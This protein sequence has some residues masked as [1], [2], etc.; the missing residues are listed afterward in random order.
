MK[1]KTNQPMLE[2]KSLNLYPLLPEQMLLLQSD[3]NELCRSIS[4]I[5]D[6][7]PKYAEWCQLAEKQHE[8]MI[9]APDYMSFHTLWLITEKE[10]KHLVGY[11][12]FNGR[13]SDTEAVEL[14]GFIKPAYRRKGYMTEALNTLRGWAFANKGV[15]IMLAHP[16]KDDVP[17]H[18]LLRK[19]S[20]GHWVEH[21][22]DKNSDIEVWCS[23]KKA[24]TLVK[25]GL[26]LG[27]GIG[28]VI[29][30]TLNISRWITALVGA[31]IGIAVCA[32]FDVKESRRRYALLKTE[33]DKP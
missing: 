3:P 14:N 7:Y 25:V 9:S 10:D 12:Y 22:H 4:L 33:Q 18:G 5:P 1:K 21:E 17:F 20:F 31:V 6:D 2:T 28:V 24:R 32:V 16:Q 29:G 8:K 26:L 19:S 11:L 27:L 13:P 30:P 23:E 15:T